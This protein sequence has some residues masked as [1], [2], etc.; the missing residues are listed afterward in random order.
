[1][2]SVASV[3]LSVVN[4]Q[5]SSPTNAYDIIMIIKY[6]LNSFL[7]NELDGT[8]IYHFSNREVCNS[9]DFAKEIIQINN[10]N[11]DLNP[12]SSDKFKSSVN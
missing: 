11:I 9:Y 1:M 12:I 6:F 4:D 2:S 7:I 8:D 3:K 5:F 10:F